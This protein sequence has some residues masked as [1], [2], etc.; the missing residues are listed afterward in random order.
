MNKK[1][2][3]LF[4]MFSLMK[5]DNYYCYYADGFV[6]FQITKYEYFTYLIKSGKEQPTSIIYY[7]KMSWTRR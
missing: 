3:F 5:K 2:E 4:T 7:W 6:R 1:V